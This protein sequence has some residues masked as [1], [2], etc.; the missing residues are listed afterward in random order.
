MKKKF[1]NKTIIV[2][3]FLLSSNLAVAGS[4]DPTNKFY[5]SVK[6]EV[7]KELNDQLSDESLKIEKVYIAPDMQVKGISV[8]DIVDIKV[9][10]ANRISKRY[11]VALE[12]RHQGRV[13]KV[14]VPALVGI[15]AEYIIAKERINKGSKIHKLDV[16]FRRL[17]LDSNSSFSRIRVSDLE[18]A[19]A[20]NDIKAGS[21]ISKRDLKK[22]SLINRGDR[23]VLVMEKDIVT[24]SVDVL[25]EESG[26]LNDII[27]VR[28]SNTNK[29]HKAKVIDK[30][31]VAINFKDN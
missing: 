4:D 10:G 16:E 22:V 14:V 23:V 26:D 28:N 12:L 13:K 8:E 29:K 19:V 21:V 9:I 30:Q 27:F 24:V 20:K 1:F 3:L 6:Q 5:E 17:P 15:T 31:M 2:V 25:A 11:F 18:D 7:I